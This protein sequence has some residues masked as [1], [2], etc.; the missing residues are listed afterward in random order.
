MNYGYAYAEEVRDHLRCVI[1]REKQY[2][3]TDKTN[4]GI[5]FAIRGVYPAFP[6]AGN[7][8]FLSR[9][10]SLLPLPALSTYRG[11]NIS[12]VAGADAILSGNMTIVSRKRCCQ[13]EEIYYVS[14]SPEPNVKSIILHEAGPSRKQYLSIFAGEINDRSQKSRRYS[15]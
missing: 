12:I 10:L 13:L 6:R 8:F 11:K 7:C 4:D 15:R 14:H 2:L 9:A 3:I 5:L 1:V